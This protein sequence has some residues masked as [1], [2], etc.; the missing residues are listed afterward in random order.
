MH[1]TLM[2]RLLQRPESLT[3]PEPVGSFGQLPTLGCLLLGAPSKRL[4]HF[5]QSTQSR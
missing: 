5:C 4:A 1:S 2:L 3:P